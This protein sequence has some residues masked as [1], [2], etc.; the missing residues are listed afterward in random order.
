MS[1]IDP[2]CHDYKG[3]NVLSWDNK[4]DENN[5]Y[6]KKDPN[7]EVKEVRIKVLSKY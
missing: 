6:D 5:N 1:R 3:Y 4:K 2:K 7:L